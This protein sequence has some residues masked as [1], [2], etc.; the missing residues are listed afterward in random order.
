MSYLFLALADQLFH[1]REVEPAVELA[2]DAWLRH[3]A[4]FAVDRPFEPPGEVRFA[5]DR[6]GVSRLAVRIAPVECRVIDS[7]LR[8]LHPINGALPRRGMSR[9]TSNRVLQYHCSLCLPMS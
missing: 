2:R 6:P 7:P 5:A 1:M 9:C 4:D 8:P 3:V